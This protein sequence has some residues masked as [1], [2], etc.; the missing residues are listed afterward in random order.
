MSDNIHIKLP[1]GGDK[2][3]PKGTTPLDVAKSIS[4]R[5]AQMLESDPIRPTGFSRK[6]TKRRAES[7]S[8]QTPSVPDPP[9]VGGVQGK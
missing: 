5:L 6:R 2:E 8:F 9:E 3:V 1:D 4:P 7:G